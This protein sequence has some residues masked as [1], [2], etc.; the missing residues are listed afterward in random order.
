MVSEAPGA[1]FEAAR[2]YLQLAK[3]LLGP[4]GWQ[5][6]P[7]LMSDVTELLIDTEFGLA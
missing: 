2:G 1:A 7:D 3:D 6:E 5:R 4:T